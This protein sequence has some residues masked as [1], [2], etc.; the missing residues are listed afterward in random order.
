MGNIQ[1]IIRYKNT[2]R[3]YKVI[4][5][6]QIESYIN[7][8]EKEDYNHMD[9]KLVLENGVD[10]G[11]ISGE[12]VQFLGAYLEYEIIREEGLKVRELGLSRDKIED[13]NYPVLVSYLNDEK[14]YEYEFEL[15]E[16]IGGVE[17]RVLKGFLEEYK[18]I[19]DDINIGEINRNNQYVY[20]KGLALY[21][22]I[23]SYVNR[24][25]VRQTEIK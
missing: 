1:V 2:E 16:A 10:F 18:K 3:V 20:V 7:M 4:K 15:G 25:N 22:Q 5:S 24:P 17:S 6:E 19:L 13:V 11:K 12:F 14:V 8:K 23:E 21:D 9:A